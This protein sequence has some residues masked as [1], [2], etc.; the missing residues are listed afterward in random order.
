[1]AKI[2][3]W[4]QDPDLDFEGATRMVSVTGEA[5]EGA[6]LATE[7]S[8]VVEA[9]EVLEGGEVDFLVMTMVNR[10]VTEVVIKEILVDL[11][12]V[13]EVVIGAGVEVFP[14]MKALKMVKKEGM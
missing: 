14:A 7:D 5:E 4:Q 6:I 3:R 13:M 2:L 12:V 1:M 11:I 9:V 10:M 8:I